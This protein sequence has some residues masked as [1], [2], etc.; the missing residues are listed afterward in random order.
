MPGD[1]RLLASRRA[2]I[3]VFPHWSGDIAHEMLPWLDRYLG[4]AVR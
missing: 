4:R 3:R 2:A 1:R